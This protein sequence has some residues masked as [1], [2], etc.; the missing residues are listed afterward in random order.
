[1]AIFQRKKI[2]KLLPIGS[3]LAT[4]LTGCNYGDAGKPKD[5]RGEH[6]GATSTNLPI[7]EALYRRQSHADSRNPI[8][9]PIP[10]FCTHV[11]YL[12]IHRRESAVGA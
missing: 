4:H 3:R 12:I 7:R 8:C 11:L 2:L 9:F 5:S 6:F 10:T 1:M